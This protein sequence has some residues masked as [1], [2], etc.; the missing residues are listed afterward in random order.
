M[1]SQIRQFPFLSNNDFNLWNPRLHP[2]DKESLAS[3]ATEVKSPAGLRSF[4]KLG[5]LLCKSEIISIFTINEQI[6]YCVFT[7]TFFLVLVLAFLFFCPGKHLCLSR[8][9]LTAVWLK[10]ADVMNPLKS[11]T[12]LFIL[13]LNIDV[14]CTELVCRLLWTL[15]C[16]T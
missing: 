5:R 11:H 7:S 3:S 10:S 15:K 9:R 12:Q 13:R 2:S 16:N 1:T 8:N 14:W 4:Q 6:A